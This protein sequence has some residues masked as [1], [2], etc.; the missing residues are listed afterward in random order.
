MPFTL[1]HPAAVLP[2]V[3]T[4]LVPSALFLGSVAPDLPYFVSLRWIGGDYN[5]TLTH[6]ASSL[7]WLDPA[8]ALVLLAVFH[9][10]LRRPL[11][12]LLP[13]AVA[14]RLSPYGLVWRS[15]RAAALIVVSLAVGAATHLLWD[16]AADAAGYGWST[17]LNLLSDVLGALVLLGWAVHWWRTTTPRPLPDGRLLAPRTR[18]AALGALLAL[19]LAWGVVR[20][21][22][23]AGQVCDDLHE[24]GGFSRSALADHLARELVVQ[25][26]AA[27]AVVVVWYAAVW[28]VVRLVRN[29]VAVNGGRALG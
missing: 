16:A 7:L 14:G 25:G 3:R 6:S 19:P 20:V 21:A 26:G 17:R 1:V 13:P 22:Q 28:H 8:I 29:A 15:P 11:V 27:L 23:V 5:L 24:Y 12:A 4:P 18:T 9:G 2:L 10:V